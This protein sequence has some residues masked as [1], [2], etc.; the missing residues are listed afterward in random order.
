[1]PFVG[2]MG[3]GPGENADG[4]NA[5]AALPCFELS[6]RRTDI[7]NAATP[8]K[9]RDM[10]PGDVIVAINGTPLTRGM[11]DAILSI[12]AE[13]LKK[14]GADG[15]ELGKR[16][17][18]FARG[19][20]QNF[21]AQRLLVDDA[22]A[23]GVVTTND[24]VR[25]TEEKLADIAAK[26][27]M[28]LDALLESFGDFARYYRYEIAI[29]YIMEKL[30][31]E[32]IPPVV[33]VDEGFIKAVRDQIR[34]ENAAAAAT[35]EQTLADMRAWRKSFLSGELDFGDIARRHPPKTD[36]DTRNCGYWGTFKKGEL[37]DDKVDEAAF[38]L[39]EG[40]ISDII[41]GDNEYMMLKVLSVVPEGKDAAGIA[42]NSEQR[43]V[44]AIAIDKVPFT[45][46]DEDDVL[47]RDLQGQMQAQA[48]NA[49]LT[50]LLTNG[51]NKVV[52]PNGKMIF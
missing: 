51:L 16:L 45:V 3:C 48:V 40:E 41:D 39:K 25:H 31:D 30:V 42:T 28:D 1:M 38:S 49:Y 33:K 11:F 46:E 19:Y 23:Q 10:S 21:V 32:R 52:Y 44:A 13:G 14:E 5:V 4:A 9:I 20:V 50:N 22:F 43:A 27:H 2:A 37:D 17:E 15:A 8:K 26:K 34:A 24:V 29:S 47:S 7:P 6:P 36:T 12:R 35:N 18:E